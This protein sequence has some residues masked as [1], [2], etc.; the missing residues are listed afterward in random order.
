MLGQALYTVT[1]ADLHPVMPGNRLFK[2]ADD[3][4][5][6]VPAINTSSCLD[7][8]V[9]IQAWASENNL[10]LNCAKS[11]E[12]IF[13]AREKCGQ[14]TQLPSPCM[15]TER[16]NSMN[17]MGIIINDRITATDHVHTPLYDSAVC[18]MLSV[19]Y[20]ATA[21]QLRH[22]TMCSERQSSQRLRTC[23]P[24]WAGSCSAAD[25]AKLDNFMRRCKRLTYYATKF[26]R[27]SV[28]P[29]TH[30]LTVL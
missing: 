26:Q 10:K 2:L 25:R 5:L 8:I 13:C 15:N 6:V 16:V 23:S 1:A 3:T 20:A 29:M 7:E 4:Y 19:S 27:Y 17:V 12:L 11:K 22:C 24:A 18:C 21:S 14:S 28:M 9:H 30:Y